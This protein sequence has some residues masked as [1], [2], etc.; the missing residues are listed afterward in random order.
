MFSLINVGE[1]SGFGLCDIYSTW[2]ENGFAKPVIQELSDPARVVL[3]LETVS[4]SDETINETINNKSQKLI[5]ILQLDP[6]LTTAELMEKLG[7]SRATVA[8]IIKELKEKGYLVRV[9][10]NKKGTW[11]ILK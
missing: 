11:K 4:V 9:G 5:E 3:T 6:H 7:C 1:R 8:R 2:E 10:S